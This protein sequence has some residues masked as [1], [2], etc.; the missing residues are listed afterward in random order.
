MRLAQHAG[1]ADLVR[2]TVG[3]AGYWIDLPEEPLGIWPFG[4]NPLGQ[5][6]IQ[7]RRIIIWWMLMELAE[8]S[9]AIKIQHDPPDLLAPEDVAHSRWAFYLAEHNGHQGMEQLIGAPQFHLGIALRNL[10]PKSLPILIDMLQAKEKL[11]D[12]MG[13]PDSIWIADL[14][15]N[16]P[17]QEPEENDSQLDEDSDINYDDGPWE[18]P[19][20]GQE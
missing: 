2:R 13:R 6:I 9:M 5:N 18:D 14:R 7:H 8:Q 11:A 19:W 12:L 4:S 15:W 16:E 3:G 20:R 10:D 1:I 17:T